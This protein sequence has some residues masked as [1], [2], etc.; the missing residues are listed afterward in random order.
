MLFLVMAQTRFLLSLYKYCF[1]VIVGMDRVLECYLLMMDKYC[2]HNI[3]CP[4]QGTFESE[5]SAI[6]GTP[7]KEA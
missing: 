2:D 7:G 5:E 1:D 3:Y 4:N 6:H